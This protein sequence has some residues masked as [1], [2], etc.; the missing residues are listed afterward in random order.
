MNV[1]FLYQLALRTMMR[2]LEYRATFFVYMT[3]AVIGPTIS[4]LV[5]LTVSQQG[6]SLPYDREQCVTYYVLLAT[7]SLLTASWVAEYGLADAIRLGKLSPLLLRPAPAILHYVGDNLGQKAVMLPLQL[8]LV[9]LVTVVFHE[10]LRLPAEP[11]SWLLF[12][13]S[14]P[15]AAT[16]AFLLD[17]L[18]GLLAFW[19][20]DVKGIIEAK[21][22]IGAFLAGQL[23][24]LALFPDWSSGFLL[25]QPFRYT[26]S[27]PLEV[28]IGGLSEA[29]I[30]LGF[31]IQMGYCVLLWAAYHVAWRYGVRMYS[32]AGA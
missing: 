18:T 29:Q 13:V 27:F 23:V 15:M 2:T 28:L 4:L 25:L 12:A 22:L 32:V 8:P 7:V 3:G 31:A 21:N 10:Y 19:I 11:W 14:L 1:R 9:A 30:A 6:L 26:L 5:W 16:V 17:Y 24:P 20:Q